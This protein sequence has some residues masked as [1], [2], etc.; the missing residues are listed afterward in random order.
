MDGF[1]TMHV[2]YWPVVRDTRQLGGQLELLGVMKVQVGEQ[3]WL[4]GACAMPMKDG[5]FL[6]F[7]VRSLCLKQTAHQY[8]D[9][10][11]G[12]CVVTNCSVEELKNV[13]SFR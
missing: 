11:Y 7:E 2:E 6:K 1:M 12:R 10:D 9:C 5:G 3:E 8:R 13:K 4:S